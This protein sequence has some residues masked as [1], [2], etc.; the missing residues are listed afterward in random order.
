MFWA[1]SQ[2]AGI[3]D[4]RAARQHAGTGDDHRRARLPDQRVALRRGGHRL[5]RLVEEDGAL[6]LE[7]KGQRFR[8]AAVGITDGAHHA[9]GPDRCAGQFAAALILAQG[10]QDFLGAAQGEG[11]NQHL[12]PRRGD[13]RDRLHQALLLDVTVGVEA[14]AVGALQDQHVGAKAR[15]SRTVHRALRGNGDVAGDEHAALRRSQP[16]HGCAG[17]VAGVK[18]GGG[19]AGRQ[20]QRLIERNRRK[21]GHQPIRRHLVE[22]GQFALLLQ[23]CSHD[24]PRILVQHA[25]QLDGHRRGVD[26]RC[27]VA[28]ADQ[29][30]RA[31][32]VGVRVGDEDGI[33]PAAPLD[34][35]EVGELVAGQPPARLGRRA[36]AGVDEQTP[37][38]DLNQDATGADFVRTAE[39]G[40]LH[41][42]HVRIGWGCDAKLWDGRRICYSLPEGMHLLNNLGSANRRGTIYRALSRNLEKSRLSRKFEKS[43]RRFL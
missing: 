25:R 15:R 8:V 29:F 39:K 2:R 12:A 35:A 13:R 18:P 40:D 31:G 27:R 6:F 9:V 1:A 37:A 17:D 32:V 22:E 43:H 38:C 26:G 14:A 24:A 28:L 21:G 3:G 30:Q 5:D 34:E 16:N 41:S 4:R 20:G 11:G 36:D 33:Q 7:G 10:Q 42:R 19:E 23:P